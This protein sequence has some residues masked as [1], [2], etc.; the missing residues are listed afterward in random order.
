MG[1]F[2]SSQTLPKPS[3]AQQARGKYFWSLISRIVL[4]KVTI[5]HCSESYLSDIG[6][7]LSGLT[8]RR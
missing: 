6:H 7:I 2:N 3:H 4:A 1:V 8:G 5:S